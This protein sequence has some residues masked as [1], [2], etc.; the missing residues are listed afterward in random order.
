MNLRIRPF[1]KN[2]LNDLVQLTLLAFEPI[3]TSFGLVQK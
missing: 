2:D 1:K 3:F